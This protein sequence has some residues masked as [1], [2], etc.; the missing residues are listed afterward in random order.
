MRALQQQMA[1][2]ATGVVVT[3]N[4]NIMTNPAHRCRGSPG[5]GISIRIESHT[6]AGS[7]VSDMLGMGTLTF[8]RS[9]RS[10][11]VTRCRGIGMA[12]TARDSGASNW[13]TEPTT[14]GVEECVSF[15][16]RTI[17]RS[18]ALVA[19]DASAVVDNVGVAVELDTAVAMLTDRRIGDVVVSRVTGLVVVAGKAL[20]SAVMIISDVAIRVTRGGGLVTGTNARH[21]TTIEVAVTVGT[22]I[23]RSGVSASR[24]APLAIPGAAVTVAGICAGAGIIGRLDIDTG[25]QTHLSGLAVATGESTIN[26]RSLGHDCDVAGSAATGNG[27]VMSRS[28]NRERSD[29]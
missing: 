6:G 13:G 18:V 3:H 25:C 28:G 5:K 26:M 9:L 2:A 21:E 14:G 4:G 10:L 27:I 11:A 15:I 12:A 29:M 1:C 7:N 8:S 17:R 24:D 20:V 23:I 22:L 16:R 19:A